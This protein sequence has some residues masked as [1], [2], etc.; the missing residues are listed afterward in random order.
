MKSNYDRSKTIIC[1]T[2]KSYH[3]RADDPLP[4]IIWGKQSM[5]AITCV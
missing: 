1:K 4:L 5:K 2:T 3:L